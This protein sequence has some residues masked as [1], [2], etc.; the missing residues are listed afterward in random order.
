MSLGASKAPNSAAAAAAGR[1]L[2]E[3]SHL[4]PSFFDCSANASRIRSQCPQLQ[5]FIGVNID[6]SCGF[7][8]LYL[9]QSTVW[10][11]FLLGS[12]YGL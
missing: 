8:L 7:V 11:M 2:M 3:P 1:V 9:Q 4:V 6:H 5:L 10:I 12:R